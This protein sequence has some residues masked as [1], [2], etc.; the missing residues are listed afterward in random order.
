MSEDHDTF[1]EE[2]MELIENTQLVLVEGLSG[3]G[4]SASLRNI[5]NQDK[6]IYMNCESGK[7]LPFRNSFNNQ[8]ITEPH[9]VLE[10]FDEA[11]GAPKEL[12]DGAII[13]TMSFLLEM[14]ESKHVL[15]AANTM[16]AWGNYNQYFKKIMQDKVPRFDRPVLILS[17]TKEDID[18]AGVKTVAAPV[19]GALRGTGIE[20]YFSTIVAT[21]KVTVKELEKYNSDLLE[22]TDEDRLVGYKHVFQTRITK[23]TVGERIRAPMGMFTPNQT[24]MDN[25]CQKLL[26]HLNAYYN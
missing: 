7:R 10:L 24:Y 20:A 21:K 3:T 19:K 2:P 22:I 12:I 16:K 25:D 14:Y 17:H 5:R 15:T 1:N 26:D 4:K 9:A 13:D 8:R 6:W 18:E 11:I 23:E